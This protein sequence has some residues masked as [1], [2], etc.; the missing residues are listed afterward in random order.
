ALPGFELDRGGL[1]GR[2]LA[3]LEAGAAAAG[4]DDI[5]VVDREARALQAVD[6]IYLGAKDELDT[7]LVDDHCHT[8]ILE[9]VVVLLGRVEGE[10]VLETGTA[11][12]ANRDA[13]RLLAAALLLA[14]QLLDLGR[15]LVGQR[16]RLRSLTHREPL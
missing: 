1:L 10:R 16:P 13:K 8:L 2:V 6:P 9:A 5:G 15:S 4:C 11:A 3:D 7:R 12:T 14:Q